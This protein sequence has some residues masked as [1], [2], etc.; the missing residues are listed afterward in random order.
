M[1]YE[2]PMG[3]RRYHLFKVEEV[4]IPTRQDVKHAEDSEYVKSQGLRVFLTPI[5]TNIAVYQWAVLDTHKPS[6][7]IQHVRRCRP[8]T[9]I[10]RGWLG[11]TQVI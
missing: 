10:K 11:S 7:P 5:A 6:F 1:Y 4:R 8:E 3:D 2:Y 9:A